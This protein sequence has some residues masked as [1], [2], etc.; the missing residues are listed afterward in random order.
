M[1]PIEIPVAR[2]GEPVQPGAWNAMRAAVQQLQLKS[3]TNCRLKPTGR[4]TIIDFVQQPQSFSG[5]WQVTLRG[6][7]QAMVRP[8]TVNKVPATIDG[9]DLATRPAPLLQFEQL[10]LDEQDRG[11]IALHVRCDA[12]SYA[13]LS[14]EIVQ[15]ADPD[16]DDGR[17][18]STPYT[19][20]AARAFGE[21]GLQARHP[22]AMLRRRADGS[23][24][25]FQMTHFPLQ[26]R[27]A[28]GKDGKTAVRHFFY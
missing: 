7:T 11:Y 16:T 6:G 3:G 20:G 13:I 8:G 18:T 2:S 21:G 27:L 1:T 5:Y 15:V 22:L 14:A 9:V 24:A 28:F 17:A 4:G 10:E 12:E 19:G 23:V 26:H 25:V